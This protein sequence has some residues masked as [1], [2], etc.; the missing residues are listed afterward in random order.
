[1]EEF[2]QRCIFS[3]ENNETKTGKIYPIKDIVSF[4]MDENGICSLYYNHSHPSFPK[5]TKDDYKEFLKQ[6][7]KYC[8][9]NDFLLG[10][11]GTTSP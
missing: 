7:N 3:K 8:E 6:T 10:M 5:Q 11:R 9:E 4:E 1:M 2:Y